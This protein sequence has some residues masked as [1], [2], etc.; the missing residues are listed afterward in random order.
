MMMP[1]HC[2]NRWPYSA[3]Y[4]GFTR[5]RLLDR[6]LH[7]RVNGRCTRRFPLRLLI[8]CRITDD[9]EMCRDTLDGDTL[10][11]KSVD[12]F[13]SPSAVQPLVFS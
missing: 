13:G 9:V 11:Q 3:A 5:H 1:S 10:M 7:L 8:K 12:I 6:T 4:L 2:F